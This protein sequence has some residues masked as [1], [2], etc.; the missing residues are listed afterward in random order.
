LFQN[1]SDEQGNAIVCQPLRFGPETRL[2]ITAL[3]GGKM[4]LKISEDAY[5]E[6]P[7][8]QALLPQLNKDPS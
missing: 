7:A 2:H 3:M 8:L 4:T 6:N 1:L 5:T